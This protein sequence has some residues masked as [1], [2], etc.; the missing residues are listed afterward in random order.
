MESWT[1]DDYRRCRMPKA[2]LLFHFL[3]V[4]YKNKLET[5][6]SKTCLVVGCRVPMT[7]KFMHCK[8]AIVEKL[9][10]TSFFEAFNAHSPHSRTANSCSHMTHLCVTKFRF[11]LLMHQS[12]SP[13]YRILHSIDFNAIVSNELL[14]KR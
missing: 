2:M 1:N 8:C 12:N 3:C 4:C 9:I 10:R 13:L 14:M 6:N 5:L 7:L 11:E